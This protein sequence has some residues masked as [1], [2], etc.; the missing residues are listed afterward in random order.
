MEWFM[1]LE[2]VS[3]LRAP[4]IFCTILCPHDPAQVRH[5]RLHLMHGFHQRLAELSAISPMRRGVL[6]WPRGCWDG[7]LSGLA[8][9]CVAE[10][11]SLR[12]YRRLDPALHPLELAERGEPMSLDATFDYGAAVR[13][14]RTVHNDG[15][16]P[17]RSG[18]LLVRKGPSA[19]VRDIGSF[20]QDQVITRCIFSKLGY[21]GG[22]ASR[23]CCRP[24][25]P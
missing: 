9:G 18:D 16:F 22:V 20:L 15:S 19:A 10:Q 14:V 2:G 13:L 5:L 11:S 7:R 21:S 25:R 1:S 17:A 4:R 6:P 8:Q 3:E 12:V 23:S 24:R